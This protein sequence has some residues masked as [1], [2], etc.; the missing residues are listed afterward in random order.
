MYVHVYTDRPFRCSKRRKERPAI[1][2]TG[3][4]TRAG[5]DPP[6]ADMY[7]LQDVRYLPFRPPWGV[8]RK[9]Q[10]RTTTENDSLRFTQGR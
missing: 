7:L 10:Q 9:R 1:G 3:R 6:V 4:I 2:H 5:G 8:D